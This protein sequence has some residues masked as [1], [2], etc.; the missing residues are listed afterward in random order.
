MNLLVQNNECEEEK[1]RDLSSYIYL[2]EEEE[3]Q[4]GNNCLSWKKFQ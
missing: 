2:P 3:K 4:D 1:T